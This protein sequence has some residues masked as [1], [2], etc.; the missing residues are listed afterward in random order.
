MPGPTRTPD[1]WSQTQSKITGVPAEIYLQQHRER[2]AP[3]TIAP[4]DAAAIASQ[5]QVADVF[6]QA[7]VI[8]CAGGRELRSGATALD[9]GPGDVTQPVA[10]L[11]RLRDFVARPRRPGRFEGGQEPEILARGRPPAGATWSRHDDWLADAFAA[12]RT[13]STTNSTGYTRDPQRPLQHRQFRLG[14]RTGDAGP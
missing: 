4:V 3:T 8:P 13:R 5:Q 12:T 10:N 1:A 7:G 11:D 9:Q 6:A 2:S 14:P